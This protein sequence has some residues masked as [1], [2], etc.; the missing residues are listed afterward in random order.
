MVSGR[1]RDTSLVSVAVEGCEGQV[2]LGGS[3]E[4][5]ALIPVIER[6]CRGVDGV[7][8]VSGHMACPTDASRPSH[9]GT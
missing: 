6:L 2:T 5:E 9:D 3:A 1:I 8:S 7:V 4:A